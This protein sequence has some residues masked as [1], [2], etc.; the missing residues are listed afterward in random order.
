MKDPVKMYRKFVDGKDELATELE[1]MHQWLNKMKTLGPELV[2]VRSNHD[3]FVDR[4]IINS[5]WKKNIQNSLEY[6]K[7]AQPLLEGTAKQG[8]I[9]WIINKEHPE[10]TTLGRDSSYRVAEFECGQHGDIGANGSR[11]SLNGFRRLNTKMVLGH[12]H[13]PARKDGVLYVGTSSKLRLG[14][15]NG[16][17]NWL[18]GHVIIYEDGK[19]TNIIFDKNGKYTTLY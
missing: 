10:I 1:N 5:D 14:Y 19:A 18:N 9:P 2:I 3:D 11:G 13:S 16:P 15:N 12:T 17:S 7:Y 8:I 4:W 6:M